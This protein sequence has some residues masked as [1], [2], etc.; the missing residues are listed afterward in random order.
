[1]ST[2]HVVY[3]TRSGQIISVHHGTSDIDHARQRAQIHSKIAG[4]RMAV[5]AVPFHVCETG[6]QYMI[7]IDRKTLIE[8]TADEQG[9]SFGFGR[10][11]S[12]S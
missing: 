10:T 12:L 3:D 1:V 4:E 7:D 6:K 8:T 11:G 5:I 9:I 2:A